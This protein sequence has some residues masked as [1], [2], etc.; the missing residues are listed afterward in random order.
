MAPVIPSCSRVSW[1]AGANFLLK[2][3][4]QV[5]PVRSSLPLAQAFFVLDGWLPKPQPETPEAWLIDDGI[6]HRGA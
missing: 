1:K 2:H 5:K 4:R 3:D 6:N